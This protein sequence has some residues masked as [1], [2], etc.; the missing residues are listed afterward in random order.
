MVNCMVAWLEAHGH[1]AHGDVEGVI[2]AI[3]R[4]YPGGF[5][6]FIRAH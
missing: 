5:N 3:D 4:L 2:W 1:R 6:R